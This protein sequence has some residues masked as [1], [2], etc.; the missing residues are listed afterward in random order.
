MSPALALAP[1]KSQRSPLLSRL[2]F[3]PASGGL[4][5][6]VLCWCFGTQKLQLRACQLGN[7]VS[8]GVRALG[9]CGVWV[10]VLGAELLVLE[11]AGTTWGAKSSRG[12]G[13]S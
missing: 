10:E 6:R 13:P 12:L 11:G 1:G 9:E 4:G 3:L 2:P 8:G 7:R 5:T